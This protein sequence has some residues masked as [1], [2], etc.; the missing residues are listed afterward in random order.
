[1]LCTFW[2]TS[3]GLGLIE[4]K[5]ERYQLAEFYFRQALEI[6]PNNPILLDSFASVNQ[7]KKGYPKGLGTIWR[8]F[9]DL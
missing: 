7:T 6:T 8:S 1:M 2:L 3:F 5:Q 9:E 4:R